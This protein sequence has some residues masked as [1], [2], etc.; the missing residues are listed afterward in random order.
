MVLVMDGHSHCHYFSSW[1]NRDATLV[2]VADALRWELCQSLGHGPLG[3]WTAGL[4]KVCDNGWSLHLKPVSCWVQGQC[5]RD[6][7]RTKNNTGKGVSAVLAS[8]T[9][10][11]FHV[12]GTKRL[13]HGGRGGGS[14]SAGYGYPRAA[15]LAN[16]RDHMTD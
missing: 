11:R 13:S 5:H 16:G 4:Q 7:T 1:D 12:P 9:H 14:H 15:G 2:L 3:S 10:G 8:G 6:N